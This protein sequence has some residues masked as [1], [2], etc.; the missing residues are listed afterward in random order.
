MLPLKKIEEKTVAEKISAK[1][2][3]LGLNG[4]SIKDP[5]VGPVVTGYPIRLHTKYIY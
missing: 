2:R 4:F 1:L 3:G 5:L